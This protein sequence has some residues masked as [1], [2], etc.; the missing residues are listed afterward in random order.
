MMRAEA[1]GP[2][3]TPACAAAATR[4]SARAV[5]GP[6]TMSV[7]ADCATGTA[8]GRRDEAQG[9]RAEGTGGTRGHMGSQGAQRG[10]EGHGG[11]RGRRGLQRAAE[12]AEGARLKQQRCRR[13]VVLGGFR[14]WSRSRR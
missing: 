6:L 3:T 13:T 7:A 14:R 12:G 5:C 11:R 1:A 4:L 8:R 10:A 9:K 2:T